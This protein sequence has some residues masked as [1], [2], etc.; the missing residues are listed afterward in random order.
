MAHEPDDVRTRGRHAAVPFWR[1]IRVLS[2][3]SQLVVLAAVLLVAAFLLGNL[4][5][6]M[7]R[8]GF[9]PDFSFLGQA[10][11]F[12][13]AEHAIAYE[14]SDTF[15]TAL[16]VGLINTILVSVL[17]IVIAT[18]LGLVVGVARLSRNWLVAKLALGYVEL[19]RNTPVLVQLLVIYFV[20]F[21][22]LPPVREAIALPGAIY[23][24]QRGVYMPRPE[25]QVAGGP[26]LLVIVLA[27]LSAGSAWLV[28]GRREAAG[29]SSL[30]LRWVAVVLLL[31]LPV[32][33]WLALPSA[34]LTFDIPEHGNFN[35]TGGLKLTPEF[36]ALT[37]GLGIYTAAF[38]A[39][40][41]RGGI[42][43]VSTGQ[44]EAARA[45]GLSEGQTLRLVILPQALRV[46][47]PP[48]TSQ[49]LNL[50]KNSSLALVIGYA[51][52]FNLSRTV[53]ELTGQPVAVIVLVMGVYLVISLLT[54]L[55][56]NLY[57]RRI[58]LTER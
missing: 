23:L 37:V 11:D 24:S 36:A 39:E 1:D 4:I 17:G 2:G 27:L 43:A 21:L 54:S 19:F 49:Y 7:D 44:R 46:I 16:L 22:Q 28:A 5:S 55:L 13:I 48:L 47:I 58:Q 38:I 34:P 9:L 25:L 6:A 42:Q 14:P 29:R 10:A 26:W 52:L 57:N 30:G 33:A 31:V 32:V 8:R 56:M 51:D 3:V 35:F 41:I 40:I 50:I 12:E 45:I 53:S 15:G 20:V 18:L